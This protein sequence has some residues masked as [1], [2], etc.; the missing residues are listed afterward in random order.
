MITALSAATGTG[1]FLLMQQGGPFAC[2]DGF[3]QR[4]SVGFGADGSRQLHRGRR[5]SL[6]GPGCIVNPVAASGR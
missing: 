1:L 4:G 3:N 2:R 5:E 6:S